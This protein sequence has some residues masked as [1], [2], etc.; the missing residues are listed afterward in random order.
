MLINDIGDITKFNV[1]AKTEADGQ[2]ANSALSE[3]L[4]QSDDKSEKKTV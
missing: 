4:K 3:E 2:S 1:F